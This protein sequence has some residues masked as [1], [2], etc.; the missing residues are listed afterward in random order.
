MSY[1]V[2]ANRHGVPGVGRV[3]VIVGVVLRQHPC[4]T[5]IAPSSSAK[6]A[7]PKETQKRKWK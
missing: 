5:H 7:T 1:E 2:Q 4:N 6:S 3:K